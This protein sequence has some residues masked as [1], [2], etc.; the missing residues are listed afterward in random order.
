MLDMKG[1]VSLILQILLQNA[2]SAK[3]TAVNQE[4]SVD[5]DEETANVTPP[6]S[7]IDGKLYF[8]KQETLLVPEGE[9]LNNA[10]TS[11]VGDDLSPSV[12]VKQEPS[13]A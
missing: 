7:D 10:V 9:Y 12:L 2:E 1:D 8:V 5:A 4:P 3:T 11:L 13:A 6:S